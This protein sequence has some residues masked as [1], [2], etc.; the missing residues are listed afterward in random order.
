M[1]EKLRAI[2]QHVRKL[3]ERGWSRSRARDYYDL[4]RVLKRYGGELEFA[5]FA[6]LLRQKCGVRDV[7]FGGAED[8][9]REP[10]LS[11]VERTWQQW[12]GPLVAGPPRF[13]TV[14]RELREELPRLLTDA[15]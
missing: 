4:W 10:M 2:L 9:F 8:F 1:A 6:S 5:G 11:Y 3:E 14:I 12:L 13:D 15:P 7:A